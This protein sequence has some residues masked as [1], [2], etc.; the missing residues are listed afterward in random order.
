MVQ[1]TEKAIEKINSILKEESAKY[2]RLYVEGGGC[3]GFQYGFKV[4]ER[5]EEDDHLINDLILIDSMSIQYLNESTI[6][7]KKDL[8]GE[9]FSIENPN[10]TSK[11]GCGQSFQV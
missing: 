4:E 9:S 3:S 2:V 6:D 10:V 1:I 8:M 5:R 11:C 7:Y